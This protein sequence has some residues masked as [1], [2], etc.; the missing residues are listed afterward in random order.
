MKNL[1]K[2]ILLCS[3]AAIMATAMFFSVNTANAQSGCNSATCNAYC[4]EGNVCVL[5]CN[6]VTTNCYGKSNTPPPIGD[7]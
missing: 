6:G 7:K 2:K 3:G 4:Y 1:K 5:I